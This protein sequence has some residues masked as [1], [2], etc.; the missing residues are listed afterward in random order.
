[1][2]FVLSIFII[3]LNLSA[4]HVSWY[5]NYEDAHKLALKQNKTIMVLL[6]KKDSKNYIPVL[7]SKN[8]LSSYP[9]EM[10]FTQEYSSL[11][12]LDKYE[13]FDCASLKGS[14]TPKSLKTHLEKCK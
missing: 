2:K 9:I 12:F 11:F 14:I 5:A 4:N 13:L 10:L 8:Q 3:S 1:M 7:I 6:I